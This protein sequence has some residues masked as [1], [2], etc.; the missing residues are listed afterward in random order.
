MSTDPFCNAA[1][2]R[3]LHSHSLTFISLIVCLNVS[4][5]GILLMLEQG[6]HIEEVWLEPR[7][8]GGGELQGWLPR[9]AGLSPGWRVR[10]PGEV[11]SAAPLIGAEA[12]F[13]LC[14]SRAVLGDFVF[15]RKLNLFDRIYWC[16]AG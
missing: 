7:G 1:F 5:S 8:W 9:E 12:W 3:K 4:V 10:C 2:P 16:D 14:S 15:F 6:S 11:G 13:T